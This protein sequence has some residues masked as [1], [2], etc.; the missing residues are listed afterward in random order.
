MVKLH[1]KT[2]KEIAAIID[3]TNLKPFATADDIERL[4]AEAARYGFRCACVHPSRVALAAELL[5]GTGVR[6]CTVVGFPLGATLTDVKVMEAVLAAEFGA[7]EFD[8]VINVGLAKEGKFDAVEDDIR[9]VVLALK[10]LDEKY[11]VKAILETCYLTDNEKVKVAKAA[12]DAGVDFV[13]TSTGFGPAGATV[14]DVKLLKSA[15]PPTVGVKASGGIRTLDQLLALVE[16]GATRIGTSASVK[17]I[18]EARGRF[19][20]D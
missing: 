8:V 15:V 13:K 20:G 5:K 11:V 19:P 14:E 12:A 17:I 6:V 1:F 3:H 7:R 10:G 9:A 18:E 16:A 4:C 2:W